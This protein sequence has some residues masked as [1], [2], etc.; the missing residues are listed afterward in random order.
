MT[1]VPIKGD[2]RPQMNRSGTGG[3][4]ESVPITTYSLTGASLV[5]LVGDIDLD[6][7]PALQTAFESAAAAHSWVIVD[8]SRVRIIESVGLSVLVTAGFVAR[9]D[10]GDLL[11]AAP[12]KFLR[13]ARLAATLS[14]YD[15]LPQAMT[16]ALRR[17]N[18]PT[19]STATTRRRDGACR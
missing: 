8:L 3:V 18:I 5:R 13:T 6:V 10:G 19:A 9:K 16:A 14:V 15:T 12:P 7:V 2:G 17:R 11:V 4:P 1:V